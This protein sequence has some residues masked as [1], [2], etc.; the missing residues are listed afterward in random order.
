MLRPEYVMKKIVIDK[1]SIRKFDVNEEERRRIRSGQVKKLVQLMKEGKHFESPF[2]V[3]LRNNGKWRVIDGNHRLEAISQILDEDP[4]FKIEIEFAEYNVD[5]RG[6]KAIRN[7]EREI[8]SLWNKGLRE[9][10]DD[11]LKQHFKT[12]PYGELMLERLPVDLTKTSK[13]IPI[14]LLIGSHVMAKNQTAFTG[15]YAKT[16]EETVADFINIVP[17]DIRTM[18]AWYV[19]MVEVFGEYKDN[20]IWYKATPLFALYRIWFDNTR[21]V[22]RATMIRQFRKA[23]AKNTAFWI[24]FIK[25]GTRDSCIIFYTNAINNLN[26]IN[27]THYRDDREILGLPERLDFSDNSEEAEA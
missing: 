4:A 8:F 10:A 16:G 9:S 3:N 25:S 22:P 19:D 6:E 17:E 14:K 23:F 26:R 24:N 27:G 13:K 12:I 15:G 5:E 7:V 2:V 11:F 20:P 1:Q 21:S 18:R